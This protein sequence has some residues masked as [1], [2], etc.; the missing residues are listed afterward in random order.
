MAYIPRGRGG[1]DRGGRGGGRGAPRG[2]GR[3]GRGQLST[4]TLKPTILHCVSQC[5]LL[6]SVGRFSGTANSVQEDS[7]TVAGSA[8]AVVGAADVEV[9]CEA[10]VHQEVVEHPEEDVVEPKEARRP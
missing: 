2:G 8:T 5:G 10:A 3:G 7:A 1:G 4:S 9:A 6:G